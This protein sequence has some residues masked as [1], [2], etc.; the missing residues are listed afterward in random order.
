MFTLL[1]F[2]D[3]L[4]FVQQQPRL[5]IKGG[6]NNFNQNSRLVR[7]GFTATT[8]LPHHQIKYGFTA[9]TK[10]P[11]HQIKYGFTATTKLPHHQIK[12]ILKLDPNSIIIII[13]FDDFPI[14]GT[15]QTPTRGYKQQAGNS[16][17]LSYNHRCNVY[18]NELHK[19]RNCDPVLRRQYLFYSQEIIA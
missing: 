17:S 16:Q 10:L 3:P 11:H 12:Y 15:R 14:M 7:Y 19:S 18:D 6:S 13:C 5:E 4:V 9:T 2:T 1:R 8:K